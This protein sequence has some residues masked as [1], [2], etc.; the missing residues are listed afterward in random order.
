[1]TTGKVQPLDNWLVNV[2]G[3]LADLEHSIADIIGSATVSVPRTKFTVGRNPIIDRRDHV[4][5]F[6]TGDGIF[7]R[8]RYLAFDPLVRSG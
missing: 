3:F 2:L 7:N 5:T 8:L 1:L 4:V 6:Q